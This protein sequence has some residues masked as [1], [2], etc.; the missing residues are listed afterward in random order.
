MRSYNLLYRLIDACLVGW[1]V[2]GCFASGLTTPADVIK[3]RLQVKPQVGQVPYKGL[4]DCTRQV[5]QT[6]GIRYVAGLCEVASAAVSHHHVLR[7]GT[8]QG[9]RAANCP[10]RS[11]VRS[12]ASGI[13]VDAKGIVAS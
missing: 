9:H 13:R 3:T 6:E 7:Q 12:D 8:V 4:L 1:L 5:L 10:L 11:P 2:A